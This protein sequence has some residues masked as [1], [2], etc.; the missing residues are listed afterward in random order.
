MLSDAAYYGDD[1]RNGTASLVDFRCPPCRA[2]TALGG[3]VS[4]IAMVQNA[5]RQTMSYVG[6]IEWGDDATDPPR[7]LVS[8][9]GSVL[10]VNFVDDADQA[11]V[12]LP[13]GRAGR[14]HRGMHGSYSSIAVGTLAAV[15][16]RGCSPP[17]PPCV[18]SS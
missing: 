18:R 13:N 11:L 1:Q 16:W 12:P 17:T 10:K 6:V 3:F 2:A 8:F 5:T 14:V 15:H 9:R 7:I 4:D